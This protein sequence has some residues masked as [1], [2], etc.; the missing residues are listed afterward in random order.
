[1]EKGVREGG[2]E[3]ERGWAPRTPPP[4][5][6]PPSHSHP[7]PLVPSQVLFI[8]MNSF[9]TSEDT[10]AF[11]AEKHAELLK[12]WEGAWEGIEREKVWKGGRKGGWGGEITASPP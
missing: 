10:R 5:T 2:G 4:S 3:G 6:S 8:L 11:L 7:S 12:V 1:M 9:S